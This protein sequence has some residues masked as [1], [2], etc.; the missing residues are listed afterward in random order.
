MNY[1]DAAFDKMRQAGE[2][3]GT[4]QNLAQKRHKRIRETVEALW[5]IDKTFLTGSYDRHTK[6]KPLEDVDIFAIIKA[7]GT[8][9][10]FRDEA[11]SNIINA[12]NNEL[13]G[14][15]KHVEPSGMAVRISISDDDGQASFELVPAFT[16]PST[17][18]EAPDPQRGRWIRTDPNV[19]AQLTSTKNGACDGRWVP[20]VKMLKGWNRQAGKPISQS[21]LVEVMALEL[22]HPPFG[23]YQDEMTA[24]LGNVVD[25]AAGP[26]PDPASLGPDVYELLSPF[27]RET[28]RRAATNAL[29][30]A[31]EAIYLE[32]NGQERK[33]VDRWR[34]L[35]GERMPL[36]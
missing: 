20:F 4:E 15:F 23:R 18:Y 13:T 17:G 2:I 31:E 1:V 33:A 3:T 16:H 6:I 26:W 30:I 36:P 19:H 35:F 21:F 34:E 25:R 27:E 24:F 11:P 12:L 29:A 7:R 28:I 14:K 9:A 10:H 8:Q 32:D 5:D 22:V